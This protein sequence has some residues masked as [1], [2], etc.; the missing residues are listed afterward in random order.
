M[1]DNDGRQAG[2]ALETVREISRIEQHG[3]VAEIGEYAG[4]A[5]MREL[6]VYDCALMGCL[7]CA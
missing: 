3:G 1:G 6:H 2:D 5:K 7:A 4:M